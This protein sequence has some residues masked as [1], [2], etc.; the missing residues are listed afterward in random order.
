M[1]SLDSYQIKTANIAA[2]TS[3]DNTIVAAVAG[4]QIWVLECV[5]M[6]NGTV[7]VKFQSGASGTDITGLFYLIANTG[8]SKNHGGGDRAM[9][10]CATATGELLN[11][12]LSASIAVGGV[13]KY[14]EV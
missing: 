14:I 2:S 7:N 1:L 11:L 5:L 8:F 9:P 12:N 3:G 6:A 13:L 4:K 10:L